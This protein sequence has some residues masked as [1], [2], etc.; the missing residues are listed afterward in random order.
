MAT[1]LKEAEFDPAI[2]RDLMRIAQPN[3]HPDAIAR[4]WRGHLV[5][6]LPQV[7]PASMTLT[8]VYTPGEST[9]PSAIR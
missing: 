2:A 1:L 4:L 8:N 5:N 6:V 3:A 9:E 7:T